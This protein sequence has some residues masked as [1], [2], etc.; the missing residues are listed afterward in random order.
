M[1]NRRVIVVTSAIVIGVVAGCTSALVGGR[2]QLPLSNKNGSS[3]I[4]A[5]TS[6]QMVSAITNAFA[7]LRYRQ[8]FLIQAADF[9]LVQGWH[10]TNGFV[11]EPVGVPASI[12]N[13]PLDRLG[14]QRVPYVAYFHVEITVLDTDQTKVTVRTISSEVI[15]GKEIFSVHGGTANHYRTVPPVRQEEE[16]VLMAILEE[17]AKERP[18]GKTIVGQRS[19]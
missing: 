18:S 1:G 13:V 4:F 2:P 7:D 15:D 14:K 8:M 6:S 12:T 16:N 11:L 17:L 19:G 9:D 5:A 3:R 10:S